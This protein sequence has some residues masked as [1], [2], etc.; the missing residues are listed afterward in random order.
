MIGNQSSG[1]GDQSWVIS[2]QDRQT[3]DR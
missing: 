3:S 2:N 1:I